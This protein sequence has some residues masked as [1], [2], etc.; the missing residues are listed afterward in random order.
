MLAR[1]R[2]V[3]LAPTPGK[4]RLSAGRTVQ[5]SLIGYKGNKLKEGKKKSSEVLLS[6]LSLLNHISKT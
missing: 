6:T 1:I 5:S 4:V 3:K 2:D